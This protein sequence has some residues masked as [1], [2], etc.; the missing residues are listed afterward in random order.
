MFFCIGRSIW[1]AYQIP[2]ERRSKIGRTLLTGI[3]VFA[4]GFAIW[5]VDNYFC[6]SLRRTRDW[7]TANGLHHL[8]HFTQGEQCHGLTR[9]VS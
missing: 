4:T 7:F 3:T 2:R 1:L 5:N 8:G 6:T 9:S